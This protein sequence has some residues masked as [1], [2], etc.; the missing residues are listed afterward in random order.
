MIIAFTGKKFSGKSTACS[1]LKDKGY[2]EINFADPLKKLASQ[3]SGIPLEDFYNPELKEIEQRVYLGEVGGH[4]VYAN[5][6]RHALQYLGTNIFRAKDKNHWVNQFKST[7]DPTKDYVCGDL[8]FLN[9]YECIK[10]LGGTIININRLGLSNVDTHIS[11][12]VEL[13][14][15]YM[16]LNTNL[17]QFKDDIINIE[18]LIKYEN[19]HKMQKS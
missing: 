12:N 5:S 1:I 4:T 2:I 15:D 11:E 6:I 9:E 17:D 16:I 10:E 18:A 7:I 19:L 3:L 14:H 13:P 8:R